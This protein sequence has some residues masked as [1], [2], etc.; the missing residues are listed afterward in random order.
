MTQRLALL[1]NPLN[2]RPT[3]DVLEENGNTIGGKPIFPAGAKTVEEAC[4]LTDLK[5]TGTKKQYDLMHDKYLKRREY[6]HTLVEHYKELLAYKES[7][8]KFD[9]NGLPPETIEE[10]TNRKLVS[11]LENEIHRTNV[12]YMEAEHIRKKYR[13]IQASLMTDAERFEK[14]LKELE[15]ALADQ[16]AEINRLQQVHKEAIEMRDAARIILQRQ[17]QQT[18][19]SN[20][21]RE[22]QAMDYRRKVEERKIELERIER[23]LFATG[24]GKNALTHQESLG[25]SSGDQ[26]TGKTD[27][28][29]DENAQLKAANTEMEQIFKKLMEITGATTPNEVLDRFISQKESTARLTYLRTAAEA[30]KKHLENQR[31]T[32][33]NELEMSKFSDIKETEVNQELLEAIKA[34]IENL[35]Q[36]NQNNLE[37]IQ[38]TEIVITSINSALMEMIFK[39]QEVDE[40]DVLL[41][42]AERNIFA[43][44]IPD[45]VRNRATN[46][47]L[48]D[49][50]NVK[51]NRALRLSQQKQESEEELIGDVKVG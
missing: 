41:T 13:S 51:L 23:T 32:L 8:Q 39:L 30:E 20:K 28:Q 31:E 22:R 7:A 24:G 19:H 35:K 4:F 34:D 29:E 38:K 10:D 49:I 50:L 12:Q 37:E 6:F 36:E 3:K 47:D 45:Y 26:N 18:A 44:E 16:Q 1:K 42:Q 15:H 40:T 2:R 9:L 14:S 46:M 5:V 11:H 25:S 33:T 43:H 21:A 27:Q 17:E 48:I